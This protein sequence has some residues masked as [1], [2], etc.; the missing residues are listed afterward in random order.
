MIGEEGRRNGGLGEEMTEICVTSG[1]FDIEVEWAIC[2]ADFCADDWFNSRLVGGGKEGDGTVEIGIGDGD[3]LGAHFGG[4]LDE[5]R[6][7]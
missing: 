1:V 7:G 2:V 3:R 6:D 5:C 4:S